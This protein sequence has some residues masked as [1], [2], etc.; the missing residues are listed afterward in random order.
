MAETDRITEN[1]KRT[2]VDL[3][4]RTI[5]LEYAYIINYPRLID[6]IVAIEEVPDQQ[7]AADL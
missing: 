7:I 3:L 5:Q 4:N 2:M 6:Q 1:A